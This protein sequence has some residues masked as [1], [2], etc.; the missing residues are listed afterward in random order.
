MSGVVDDQKKTHKK[1]EGSYCWKRNA[2][3]CNNSC[4]DL[5]EL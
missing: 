4:V 2:K 1:T 3:G 5:I